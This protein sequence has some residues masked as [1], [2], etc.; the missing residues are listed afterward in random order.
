MLIEKEISLIHTDLAESREHLRQ[1]ADGIHTLALASKL[2]PETST[3][4]D[5]LREFTGWT[6][7]TAQQY[8]RGGRVPCKKIRRGLYEFNAAELRAWNFMGRPDPDVFY[9]A[10]Q[11]E[12]PAVLAD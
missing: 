10:Y 4:Y 6:E 3:S 2:K 11:V 7:D 8:C 5:F 1:M 9:S 12:Q